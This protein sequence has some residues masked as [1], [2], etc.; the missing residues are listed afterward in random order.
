MESIEDRLT[1][2]EDKLDKIWEWIEEEQGL[3]DTAV[4]TLVKGLGEGEPS[5]LEIL[6]NIKDKAIC[7]ATRGLKPPKEPPPLTQIIKMLS[8]PEVR[9]GLYILLNAARNLGKC[10]ARD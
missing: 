2:I 8:D 10:M 3:I 4:F 6:D 9:R 1:R 5:P 7:M